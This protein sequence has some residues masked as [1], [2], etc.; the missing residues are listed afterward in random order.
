MGTAAESGAEGAA[1]ADGDT[2]PYGYGP[3]FRGRCPHQP[4]LYCTRNIPKIGFRQH[5]LGPI[6]SRRN[7]WYPIK[8][9]FFE[10]GPSMK[11]NILV[12]CGPTA[13]GKT[14]LAA[15]LALRFGGIHGFDR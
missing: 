12:I 14:A 5:P 11:P 3:G 13:S 8:C 15:E 9:H 4:D 7:L 1:R 2:G 6:E 10:R